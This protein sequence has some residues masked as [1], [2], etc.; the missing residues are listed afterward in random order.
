MAPSKST[1][2]KEQVVDKLP[3]RF[4][5]LKFGIQCV[6]TT[7]DTRRCEQLLTSTQVESG[8]RKP[9]RSRDLQPIAIRH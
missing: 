5:G 9:S 6:P 7:R 1:T 2:N 4:K 3:K 8:Y